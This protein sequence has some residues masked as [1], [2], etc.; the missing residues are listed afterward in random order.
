MRKKGMHTPFHTALDNVPF[1][2]SACR[3]LFDPEFGQCV[4]ACLVKVIVMIETG[5]VL[6]LKRNIA[7]GI[8]YF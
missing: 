3:V 5:I 1:V 4:S 6:I 2:S 7:M 8:G